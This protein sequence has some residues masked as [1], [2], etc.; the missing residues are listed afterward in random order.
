MTTTTASL[1]SPAAPVRPVLWANAVFCAGSAIFM[2]AASGWLSNELD[3]A[4]PVV[5]AVGAALAAYAPLVAWFA[6]H[7]PLRRA[8]VLL[9]FQGDLVW[10]IG[11]IALIATPDLLTNT[12]RLWLAIISIPVFDFTVLE[13]VRRDSLA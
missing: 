4:Q 5:L 6:N 9:V 12:A 8:H 2:L 10:C 3:L 7:R 11:A 13:W 1:R